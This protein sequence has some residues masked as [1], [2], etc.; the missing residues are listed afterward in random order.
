MD[1]KQTA[2]KPGP[3]HSREPLKHAGWGFAAIWIIT[4]DCILV[5]LFVLRN[6]ALMYST[7]PITVF[8]AWAHLRV[9]AAGRNA[10]PA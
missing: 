7:I 5:N 2:N 6:P 10:L 8:I 4:I 1:R 3:T 9:A